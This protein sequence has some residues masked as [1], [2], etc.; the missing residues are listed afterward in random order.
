MGG[1]G[2]AGRTILRNT[3]HLGE[4]FQVANELKQEIGL[5]LHPRFHGSHQAMGT[6]KLTLMEQSSQTENKHAQ[7]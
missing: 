5:K 4:E 3:I 2:K 1:K 6:I 7:V